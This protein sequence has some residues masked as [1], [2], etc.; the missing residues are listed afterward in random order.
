MHGETT[1][2]AT[3]Q[4]TDAAIST[5]R[6][7]LRDAKPL[8]EFAVRDDAPRATHQDREKECFIRRQHN[9]P[10]VDTRPSTAQVKP[11]RPDRQSTHPVRPLPGP[12]RRARSFDVSP[13][14]PHGD[15]PSI[16][17]P[18]VHHSMNIE[19]TVT[20]RADCR[21]KRPMSPHSGGAR[22]RAGRRP[23]AP[24]RAPARRRARRWR[25]SSP[26]RTS[27]AALDLPMRP[28]SQSVAT[29]PEERG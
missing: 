19:S 20:D 27:A 5:A 4:A 14:P 15:T 24:P 13:D 8:R 9:R 6:G 29:N 18:P 12:F 2:K 10:R 26:L 25:R 23:K 1:S 16:T 3:A 7:R 22:L 21:T 28:L 17:L 11:D